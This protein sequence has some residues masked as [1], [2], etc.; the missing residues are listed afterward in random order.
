[1][2][3]VFVLKTHWGQ[4]LGKWLIE[5]IVAYPELGGL[6][7]FILATRDAHELYRRYGQFEALPHP[8]KW[9]RRRTE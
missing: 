4:G 7:L 3:D 6:R 2:C 8:E 1:L 9:M 5:N